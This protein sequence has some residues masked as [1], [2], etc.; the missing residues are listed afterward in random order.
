MP[1]IEDTEFSPLEDL[2]DQSSIENDSQ[3]ETVELPS[4]DIRHRD[5]FSGLLFLGGLNH[6]FSYC[7][8]DFAI[9]TLRTE[10]ILAIGLLVKEYDGAP[11]QVKAYATALVAACIVTIDGRKF[12]TP[13][14]EESASDNL[15]Y[16]FDKV[17]AWYPSSI[18]A[19]YSEYIV[20]EQRV[21]DVFES[22]G[23]VSG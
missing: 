18:D 23:K 19:I 7:G 9:R 21:N 1:L 20:L 14:R 3:D 6:T 13:F 4:F 22:M 17:A 11:S 15:R 8:H 5:D 2:A 16:R 12:E 10:E